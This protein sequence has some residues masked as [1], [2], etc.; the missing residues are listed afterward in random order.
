MPKRYTEAVSRKTDNT[1][2]KRQKDNPWTT[3]Q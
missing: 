2:N 1:M 3:Q